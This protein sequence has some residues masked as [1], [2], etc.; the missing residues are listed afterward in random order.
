MQLGNDK[1]RIPHRRSAPW[2]SSHAPPWDKKRQVLGE[3]E[4]L[5][6]AT[7]TTI[8]GEEAN[9]VQSTEA[10]GEVGGSLANT[11]VASA[12]SAKEESESLSSSMING[13]TSRVITADSEATNPVN[14]AETAL[15]SSA[16]SG[17]SG[18]SV[19][20]T[21]SSISSSEGGS[22]MANPSDTGNEK[23]NRSASSLLAS[24]AMSSRSGTVT[25]AVPVI[26]LASA[27]H[28]IRKPLALYF[29][30]MALPFED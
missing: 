6:N 3:E 27:L 8:D 7:T 30:P 5:G 15:H 18:S 28:P 21:T 1:M 12:T 26:S 11:I 17:R 2:R 22:I 9:I 20:A 29:F 16:S 13:V 10:P 24:A 4:L 19:T 25:S 23:S 14:T